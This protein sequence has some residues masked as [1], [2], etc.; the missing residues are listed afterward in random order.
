MTDDGNDLYTPAQFREYQDGYGQRDP[1]EVHQHAGIVRDEKLSRYLSILETHYDPRHC[2]RPGK[3]PGQAKDLSHV[4]EI[5]RIEGTETARRAMANGDMQSLK[6]FTGDA[7]QRADISGI[8]AIDQLRAQMTGPAPMFYE[9]AEPG[10]GKSNFACLLGQLWKEQHPP[11]ALVASNI[12]TL[13][14]TDEWTDSDG[15]RR[16]GWLANYGELNEW[17]KQ[18][19][20][21]MHNEQVP[22]LFI[23]DEASSNAGGSGSDGYETKT[24]LG[25]LTYKIRKYGGS[26]IIIGHDG[27]DVHPLVRELGVCVHKEGL[28]EATFYEDVRNRKGVNPIFSVSGIPET[29]WRYDDKEPTTWS[30]SSGEDGGDEV[31]PADLSQKLA[32]YTV[33]TAKQSEPD[34]PNHEIADFVPYSAEWV[35]QRWNEYQDDGKHRNVVG[36]V[37]E[38]TA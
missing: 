31:D 32:I 10:T 20:D 18:D 21:P 37:T 30:W 6:H 23:F 4:R 25:P 13:E 14:E 11:D 19:G 12:R 38:L 1:D 22:K 15:D 8:K 27:R 33:I 17:L 2:D 3:M 36:E 16:D 5:V 34:R 29:D 35:R 26:L 24:K 9:W 28:K 7:G